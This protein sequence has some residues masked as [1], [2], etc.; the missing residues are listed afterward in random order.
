MYSQIAIATVG[1]D[2]QWIEVKEN[3]IR[4][5]VTLHELPNGHSQG[6]RTIYCFST[7][8]ILCLFSRVLSIH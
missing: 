3:D 5:H 1:D 7:T 2:V 8:F 6:E 4:F